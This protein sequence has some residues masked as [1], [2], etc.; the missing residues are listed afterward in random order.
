MYTKC[1]EKIRSFT[2]TNLLFLPV[3]SIWRNFLIHKYKSDVKRNIT[4]RERMAFAHFSEK[5]LE[6]TLEM[7]GV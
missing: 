2:E 4:L 5:V 3:A 7:T 6:I 1:F